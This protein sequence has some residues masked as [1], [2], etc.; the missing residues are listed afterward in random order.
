MSDFSII[1]R[2]LR[3]R[4]FSTVV[5]ILT[6]AVAVGLFLTLLSM[7]ESGRDAFRRGSGNID[8]LVSAEPGPL[9][10]VLNGLFH[11]GAP[12]N[13][14]PWSRY[15]ALRESYPWAWAIPLQQG[16][17][18]QGYPAI[19]TTPAFF[20]DYQPD[21]GRPWAFAEGRPFEANF[22][23]VVGSDVAA[24]T[25]VA[26]GDRITLTHGSGGSR[27]DHGHSHDEYDYSVVGILEPSGSAHD[28]ALFT[29]LESSWVL[30]A[31][32]RHEAEGRHVH[33][34]VDDLEEIDRAVTGVLLKV[35]SRG[36]MTAAA[37]PQQFDRLRREGFTVAQPAQEIGRLLGIV[38]NVDGLLIAMAAAVLVASGIGIML[39]LYNSMDQR[40]RQ[41]AIMRVLG[42]SR[43]KVFSLTLTE[44]ALIGVAGGVVG[45]LFAAIGNAATASTLKERLGLVIPWSLDP[46]TVL[47]VVVGTTI[48]A[49]AAG[50]LPGLVAYRTPVATNLRPAA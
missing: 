26:V 42:A 10:S 11:A 1:L 46:A 16:D 49:A 33:V 9:V 47:A 35:P 8:L 34:G 17:N 21:A 18:Y 3:I 32:D 37:L 31:F 6:V 39:A 7:R 24:T 20:G 4:L 27:E 50:V 45:T 15:E 41:V 22:E 40:R 19:A 29:D 12:A 44:S 13:P 14:I 43:G 23:I 30:H 38:A 2:S 28:R 25:G 36:G 48:L 5:T